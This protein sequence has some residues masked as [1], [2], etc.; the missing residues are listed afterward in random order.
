MMHTLSRKPHHIE[1]PYN[2]SSNIDHSESHEYFYQHNVTR[3]LEIFRDVL[4]YD[5]KLHEQPGRYCPVYFF[6][7]KL[8]ATHNRFPLG[9][10][11]EAITELQSNFEEIKGREGSFKD[12]V[13]SAQGFE[14]HQDFNFV[15]EL[16]EFGYEP[17]EYSGN[18]GKVLSTLYNHEE[19]AKLADTILGCIQNYKATLEEEFL[20]SDKGT[21]YNTK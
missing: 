11:L 4:F 8:Y 19:A 7:L 14:A 3:A 6:I 21:K 17:W 12:F 10:R 5:K 16:L 20:C 13:K 1:D 2:F 9:S 15:G 18:S